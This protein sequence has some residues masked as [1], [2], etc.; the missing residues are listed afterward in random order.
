MQRPVQYG[1][2]EGPKRAGIASRHQ[3]NRGA[4][5]G[6][7]DDFALL[8]EA[9]QLVRVE[10]AQSA[11]QSEV[12][13]ERL[14]RLHSHQVFERRLDRGGVTLKQELPRKQRPIERALSDRFSF[15]RS[16]LARHLVTQKERR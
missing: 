5:Q 7:A 14:L 3:M 11:P 10:P 13:I 9:P 2:D 6:D 16:N 12:W 8:H 15:V 4:H 1:L